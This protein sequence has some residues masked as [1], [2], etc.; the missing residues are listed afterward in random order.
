MQV[1]SRGSL[2]HIGRKKMIDLTINA[3]LDISKQ[4]LQLSE[5]ILGRC[6]KAIRSICSVN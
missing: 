6:N 2:V 5:Q 1:L 3:C 4:I